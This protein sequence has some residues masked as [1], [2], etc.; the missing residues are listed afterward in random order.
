MPGLHAATVLASPPTLSMAGLEAAGIAGYAV[1]VLVVLRLAVR[2]AERGLAGPAEGDVA[3]A[4]PA[5]SP[6]SARG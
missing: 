6:P 2:W 5:A 4:S 3:G 1:L